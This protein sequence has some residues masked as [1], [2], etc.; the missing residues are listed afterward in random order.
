MMTSAAQKP[1][2]FEGVL[3][4]VER[5]LADYSV[6]KSSTY[7]VVRSI[8]KVFVT[9]ELERR[10]GWLPP[11]ILDRMRRS[12]LFTAEA[13]CAF[14]DNN[15]PNREYAVV[16][17]FHDDLHA[18]LF[19]STRPTRPSFLPE[20]MKLYSGYIRNQLRALLSRR[21]DRDFRIAYSLQKGIKAEWLPLNSESKRL[22]NVKFECE[23]VAP[24]VP[25]D[26]AYVQAL[27]HI[28][29]PLIL[30]AAERAAPSGESRNA[31]Y[32]S[33]RDK[34][35]ARAMGGPPLDLTSVGRDD[36][37]ETLHIGSRTVTLQ[38]FGGHVRHAK[39]AE[40]QYDQ[41]R[42][43]LHYER[44]ISDDKY[45]SRQISIA[46]PAK[47]RY[48]T[49]FEARIAA[50][51]TFKGSL[52]AEMQR[53]HRF[54]MSRDADLTPAVTQL[55]SG[56]RLGELLKSADYSAATQLL[57]Q[58]VSIETYKL[59]PKGDFREA[60][61]NSFR[62]VDVSVSFHPDGRPFER[63]VEGR[64]PRP[65]VI[66]MTNGQ[67][68]G[69]QLSFP[70]L[71]FANLAAHR[72]AVF[73][74]AEEM[75]LERTERD[76]L[77][78]LIIVN[79]DDKLFVGPRR[80]VELDEEES[81]KIGL[82]ESVGK[83]HASPVACMINSQQFVVRNLGTPELMVTKAGYL[84]FRLFPSTPRKGMSCSDLETSDTTP[85]GFARMFNSIFSACPEVRHWLP[86]CLRP[87]DDKF[88]RSGL[89]PNWFLP[90]HLGG[91]G[92]T[93]ALAPVDNV[94]TPGQR[95]LAALMVDP[96]S[97]MTT[98]RLVAGSPEMV[99]KLPKYL[100]PLIPV[101]ESF[102][103][104]PGFF[105]QR[106]DPSVEF[107]ASPQ[108]L[109]IEA[110]L[111]RLISETLPHGPSSV[112]K[113]KANF[114]RRRTR[115]KPMSDE[116]LLRYDTLIFRVPKSESLPR[117][118]MSVASLAKRTARG[119]GIWCETDVIDPWRSQVN[120]WIQQEIVLDPWET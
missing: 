33:S 116:G 9:L 97:R 110:S 41:A 17:Y 80:L 111:I 67:P 79:G 3:C 88:R 20:G 72:R 60:V 81:L 89:Q 49:I 96:Q 71:N 82:R 22:N 37:L 108:T 39:L 103:L 85:L 58:S 112:L 70:S 107:T 102:P 115:F 30:R 43:N 86:S 5:W 74:Y 113:L 35:G 93:K 53:D 55:V 24:N 31:S 47:D 12:L 52:I 83:S 21:S 91:F 45:H 42:F 106:E 119:V 90:A 8:S 73:R 23:T 59:L 2:R 118:S 28:A 63:D 92:I 101:V 100:Q 65:R 40:Y 94:V 29:S 84:N 109:P 4:H 18:Q 26:P 98:Y 38:K 32:E 51:T 64:L 87:Y 19:R 16:K 66:P 14:E 56:A 61:L 78:R 114:L 25:L 10:G 104:T 46:E 15:F 7:T 36:D 120:P 62:N 99:A 48:L 69:H 6:N 50:M 95:R 27:V 11:R 117:F 68:M 57:S 34:G 77:L 76:R 75:A 105:P 1:S 54:A 13:L 44:I